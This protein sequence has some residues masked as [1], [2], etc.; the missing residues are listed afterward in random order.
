MKNFNFFTFNRFTGKYVPGLDRITGLDPAAP[1]FS[2]SILNKPADVLFG[3]WPA[4]LI[5][6]D[7]LTKKKAKFVDIIHTSLFFGIQEP[8]GHQDFYVS[9]QE[10]CQPGCKP[11]SKQD[12][13][14]DHVRAVNLYAESILSPKKFKTST[15]CNFW[16]T[17]YNLGL[18][19]CKSKCNHMGHYADRA[20]SQGNYY[21]ETND[22]TPFSL[23]W[24][25]KSSISDLTKVRFNNLQFLHS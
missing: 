23:T 6:G 5:L 24:Y 21:L 7:S 25:F 19:D 12:F 15:V 3:V 20:Q 9:W 8:V 1:F 4:Y 18:C 17:S 11:V 10:P 13:S 22:A 14:C 2:D 16:P